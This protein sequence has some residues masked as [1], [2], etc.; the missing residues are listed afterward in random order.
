MIED[1]ECVGRR[2]GEWRVWEERVELQ[3]HEACGP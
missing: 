3:L 1:R 2:E